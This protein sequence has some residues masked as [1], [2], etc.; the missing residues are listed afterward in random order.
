MDF[1]DAHTNVI[2]GSLLASA[3]LKPLGLNDRKTYSP[4]L[5]ALSRNALK[6]RLAFPRTGHHLYPD[7]SLEQSK[8]PELEP[9]EQEATAPG[10]DQT[11][12]YYKPRVLLEE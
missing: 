6:E 4:E 12:L 10:S 9:A 5:L 3:T 1:G 2:S 11:D 8:S 7:L